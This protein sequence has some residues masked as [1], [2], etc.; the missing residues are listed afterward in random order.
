[1][2]DTA[3]GAVRLPTQRPSAFDPPAELSE[4]REKCPITRMEFPDGH[5]GWLVTDHASVRSLLADPRFSARQ[6]LHH[7]APFDHPF[8]KEPIQPAEP[9]FFIGMDDPEHSRYRRLVAGQFTKRRIA[10]LAPRVEEIAES[11]LDAMERKGTREADL[12]AEYAQPIPA[13]VICE[14]LGVPLTDEERFQ[15]A[16]RQFFHLSSSAQESRDAYLAILRYLAEL[17]TRKR[18]NPGDDLLS[19]LIA[20]GELDDRELATISL[21]LLVAGYETTA[22]MISLGAFALLT[23]P[24]QLTLVREDEA[25]A[26]NAVEELL[27][28][29]PLFRS[30]GMRTALQDTE[31]NGQQVKAGEC[32]VL[33]LSAANR[34][35]AR[36]GEDAERLNVRRTATGHVAFG[37]GAHQCLGSQLA[38]LEMRIA[39]TSLLRRFP[40]LRL[41]VPPQD[42]PLRDDMTIHGAHRLPI[43]W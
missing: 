12:V 1:M 39:Y 30:G 11:C 6:E 14:L 33:S 40:S 35:P 4:L 17:V 10:R 9:G 25:V 15:G 3:H 18:D 32:L 22:N 8:G 13:R 31:V 34:D 7:H 27:R 24:E 28:Y 38:R 21:L 5:L 43:T 23:H 19:G 26:E 42:V 20:R 29:L 37:H 2:T 41:A 36:F 16:I